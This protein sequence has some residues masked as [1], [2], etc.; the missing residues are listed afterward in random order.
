MPAPARDHNDQYS[1]AFARVADARYAIGIL[2]SCGLA[3]VDVDIETV[4]D[5]RG[6]VQLVILRVVIAGEARDRVLAAISGGHG[7]PLPSELPST[8]STSAA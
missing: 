3:P 4:T 2:E 1:A 6:A 8:A 7:V 5:E